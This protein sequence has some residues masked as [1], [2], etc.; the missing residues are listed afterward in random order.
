MQNRHISITR[1]GLAAVAAAIGGFGAAS[2]VHGQTLL[3]S[4]VSS[5]SQVEP[6]PSNPGE[7]E[8]FQGS[9]EFAINGSAYEFRNWG[10]IQFASPTVPSGS[11]VSSVNS[12]LDLT[13]SQFASSFDANTNVNLAFYLTTDTATSIQGS[14]SPSPETTLQ[15]NSNFTG[16]FDPNAGDPGTFGQSGTGTP[17]SQIIPIGTAIYNSTTLT[18]NQPITYSLS[19]TTAAEQFIKNQINQ[20]SPVRLIIASNETDSNMA[21]W[22]LPTSANP[23]QLQF[24]VN[25][26]TVASNISLLFG[27]TYSPTNTAKT[28]NVPMGTL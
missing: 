27:G 1:R 19:L 16:G 24:D 12:D 20:S 2:I 8:L 9:N 18:A 6:A 25:T 15:Y 3:T 23:P 10:I 7:S 22:D 26:T 17:G 14:G 11:Q 4:S 28:I 21:A 13:M 5:V